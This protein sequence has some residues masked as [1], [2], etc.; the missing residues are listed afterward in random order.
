MRVLND[1]NQW[2]GDGQ[3][4]YAQPRVWDRRYGPHPS[5]KEWAEIQRMSNEFVESV[6]KELEQRRNEMSWSVGAVGKS[7]AIRTEIANQFTRGSKCIEPE[8]SIRQSAAQTID[9]ALES[10][11]GPFAVKVLAGGSQNYK[12]YSKPE[13]GIYNNLTI[14][15][16]VL[17]NFVE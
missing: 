3:I 15:I 2:V 16:E 17:H 9:K 13:D 5:E 7:P 11:S 12:N 6:V 4:V 10:I 1:N 8:E 14:T